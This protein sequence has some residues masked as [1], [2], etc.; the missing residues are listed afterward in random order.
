MAASNSSSFLFSLLIALV[1][2]ASMQLFRTQLSSSQP[3]TIA[4]GFM[5][6][7]VFVSLLTAVSNFE[8][9]LFGPNFQ[10]RVFPE[11]VICLF[12]SMIC[13]A[14]VHRVCVTTCM[15]FSLIALYY[16]NHIST[17]TYGN[18]MGSTTSYVAQ[19]KQK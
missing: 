1:L 5:G 12:T 3:L 19:K 9:N 10:A 18:T 15:I 17:T 14:F 13:C 16:I 2:F 7:L 6:S 4:G 8:M 11:V